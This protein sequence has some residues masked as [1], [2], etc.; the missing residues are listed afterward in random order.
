MTP[1]SRLPLSA[2]RIE[3]LITLSSNSWPGPELLDEVDST[4]RVL[5]ERSDAREGTTI[6]AEIQTAGRGRLGR[7][8]ESPWGSGVWMSVLV[9]PADQPRASWAWLP[10]IAALAV[11]DALAAACRLDCGLKWPNDLVSG[12]DEVRKLG[13][14]LV[15]V[16]GPEAVII[17]I[18]VNM[19]LL[20]AEL[21][22]E[23]ATSV[24]L[25]GGEPD[26]EAFVVALQGALEARLADW[27]AGESAIDDYR[28][29]CVTVGRQVTV[30]LPD[31]TELAGL[32]EGIAE[33]GRLMVNTEGNLVIVAAGDV[34][35]A[36]I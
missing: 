13:G 11:R 26:R 32:A 21:P 7:T 29:A 3:L 35:H 33:D 28:G 17:G 34:I 23:A 5:A 22:T 30:H 15:E 6:V 1:S 20:K 18:G 27:R 8:W 10:L 14:I 4:N 12:G 9:R 19:S 31:G 36:T 2:D 24:V 16:A 25:E